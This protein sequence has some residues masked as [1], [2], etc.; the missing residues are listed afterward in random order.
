LNERVLFRRCDVSS[1]EDVLQL[2]QATWKKFG[3]I[4]AVLSNAGINSENFDEDLYEEPVPKLK[5]PDLTSI[6]VNLIGQIYVVKCAL[7]YFKK[8][9]EVPCQIVMTG[10]AASYIDT[11]PLYLY[12]A[13]KAGVLGFMR[14]LRTQVVKSNVTVNMVAPWLTGTYS[15]LRISI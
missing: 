14:G 6:N 5:A 2:W 7:H 13:G 9:P 1:F 10:S 8:W 12:C 4:N 15:G 3:V 11:P